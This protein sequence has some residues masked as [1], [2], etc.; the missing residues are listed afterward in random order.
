[1]QNHN[2]IWEMLEKN[3][4]FYHNRYK[5]TTS[6]FKMLLDDQFDEA[7]KYLVNTKEFSM[8]LP[9]PKSNGSKHRIVNIDKPQLGSVCIGQL[10]EKENVEEMDLLIYQ[11]DIYSYMETIKKHLNI[12]GKTIIVHPHMCAWKLG[13]ISFKDKLHI[14]FFAFSLHQITLS[15]TVKHIVTNNE[16]PF[17]LLT[18]TN[19]LW[20]KDIRGYMAQRRSYLCSLGDM[21]SK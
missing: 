15:S 14:A 21:W 12:K 20:N 8:Y 10:C 5:G 9:C 17:L 1:M 16:F 19:N 11:F 13:R 4:M 6:W 7:K 18:P 3:D 2:R